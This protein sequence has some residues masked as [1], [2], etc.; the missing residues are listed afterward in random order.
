MVYGSY[1]YGHCGYKPTYNVWGHHIVGKI[2]EELGQKFEWQ[3]F[4]ERRISASRESRGGYLKA[5]VSREGPGGA[6]STPRRC[7]LGLE[8]VN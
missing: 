7:G 6:V 3:G 8:A 4:P 5:A 2:N 1:N